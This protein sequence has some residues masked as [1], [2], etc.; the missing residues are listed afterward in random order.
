MVSQYLLLETFLTKVHFFPELPTAHPG[1]SHSHGHGHEHGR[2][3]DSDGHNHGITLHTD[4]VTRSANA[5]VVSAQ[6]MSRTHCLTN[7]EFH[8][9][10]IT[11]TPWNLLQSNLQ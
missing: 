4:P 6:F 9:T 8:S 10:Q 1:H 11:I 3:S 5:A 7:I 2:D